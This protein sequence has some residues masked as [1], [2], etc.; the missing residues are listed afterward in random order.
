MIDKR[1]KTVFKHL[2]CHIGH[3][4]NVYVGFKDR[5]LVQLNGPF[6]NFDSL[7][8]NAFNVCADLER[9]CEESQVLGS[10]LTIQI[11]SHSPFHP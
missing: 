7:I 11:L 1:V 3:S 9:R 8:A 5:F 2:L 6:G 4:G 10:R